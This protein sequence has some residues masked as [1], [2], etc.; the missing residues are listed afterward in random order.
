MAAWLYRFA[1]R[2]TGGA[3][4]RRK[5]RRDLERGEA[6]LHRV[7]VVAALEAPEIEDEG[8]VFFIAE[9][10]GPTLFLAGQDMARYKSRGFPW[11]EFQIA[12]A[13]ESDRLLT[14]RALSEPFRDV[15]VRAPLTLAE[16]KELGVLSTPFGTL[17][18]SLEDLWEEP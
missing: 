4:L 6:A 11:R 9:A 5:V 3:E 18:R 7:R 14:L 8:P 13:P 1:G 12:Q 15:K 10:T 2:W 17:E 16:A